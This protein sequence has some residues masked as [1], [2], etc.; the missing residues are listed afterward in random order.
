MQEEGATSTTVM[1]ALRLL[2]IEQKLADE[3]V[4]DTVTAQARLLFGYG[5]ACRD[6]DSSCCEFKNGAWSRCCNP[7]CTTEHSLGLL[8]LCPACTGSPGGSS[9]PVST[10]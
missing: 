7:S 8:Q 1:C 9:M 10:A 3:A 5:L 2:T 4:V 6:W